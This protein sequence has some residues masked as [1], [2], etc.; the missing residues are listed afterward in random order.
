[1]L[2]SKRARES[3]KATMDSLKRAHRIRTDEV[4]SKEL[5]GSFFYFNSTD[6]CAVP[7]DGDDQQA[8]ANQ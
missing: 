6:Y 1:M 4:F 2:F 3:R 7:E 8:N 5:T